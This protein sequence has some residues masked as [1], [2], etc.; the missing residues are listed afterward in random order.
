MDNWELTSMILAAVLVGALVP[1]CVAVALAVLGASKE[2]TAL[3]RQLRPTVDEVQLITQ[4]VEKMS[5]GLNGGE[6]KLADLLTT[7]GEVTEGVHR[8]M[9]LL[10]IAS[11]V[12]ASV[13]PA[14]AAFIKTMSQSHAP[15]T[16]YLNGRSPGSG[17]NHR[18]DSPTAT[19][20]EDEEDGNENAKGADHG[21]LEHIR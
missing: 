9:R 13:G 11:A 15:E 19:P 17:N 14:V 18:A 16:S 3:C 10:H 5:R 21:K 4:R 20:D 6:K 8:S 2:F 7:V 1:A 12:A